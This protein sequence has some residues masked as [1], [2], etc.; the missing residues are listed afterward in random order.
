MLEVQTVL[1]V[2]VRFRA[3]VEA[4]IE[5]MKRII[6]MPCSSHDVTPSLKFKS[7]AHQSMLFVVFLF[8]LSQCV[9][10]LL[11]DTRHALRSTA[12][13]QLLYDTLYMST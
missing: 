7:L 3:H 11:I 9:V 12:L 10:A 1:L 2:A 5:K 4:I 13:T 6:T 8:A